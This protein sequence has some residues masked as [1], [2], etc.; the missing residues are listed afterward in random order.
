MRSHGGIRSERTRHGGQMT[1][2][3]FESLLDVF[4]SVGSSLSLFLGLRFG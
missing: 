3:R 4:R 2:S 1:Q